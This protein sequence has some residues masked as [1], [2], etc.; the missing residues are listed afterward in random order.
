MK[1]AL[2]TLSDRAYHGLYE[3]LSTP[4]LENWLLNNGV[5]HLVKKLISDDK[6]QLRS[7]IRFFL[8]QDTDLILTCGGTGISP[9]DITP[10]VTKEII[11][12]EIPGV[13]ELIRAQNKHPMSALS[14]AICGSVQ[15]TLILNLS[16]NPQGAV[17]QLEIVWSVLLHACL[18]IK[19]KRVSGSPC[20]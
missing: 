14:R 6:D 11:E 9:R 10:D 7:S 13:A 8:S 2:I 12:K 18:T 15:K 19:G 5:N 1:V 16:G 17:E 4:K 20:D 3:D